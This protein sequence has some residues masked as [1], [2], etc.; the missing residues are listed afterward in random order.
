M[1]ITPATILYQNITVFIINQ[2][3]DFDSDI[4]DWE[5]T[6]FITFSFVRLNNFSLDVCGYLA[7]THFESL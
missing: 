1:W 4:N 7:T 5:H 6:V 2:T 3:L